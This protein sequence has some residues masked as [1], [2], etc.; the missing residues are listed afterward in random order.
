MVVGIEQHLMRLQ[1]IG[2]QVERSAVAELEVGYLQ[3]G[4][5]AG[6]NSPVLAPV[7]LEGL[8]RTEGQGN[9]GAAPGGLLRHEALLLPDPGEGRYA[10][11]GAAVTERLQIDVH[12]LD[13]A[14]LLA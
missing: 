5:H 4:A 8:T 7:E 1:G 6:E 9:E 3:L 2:A 13:G 14:P 12:L 11:V 10:V